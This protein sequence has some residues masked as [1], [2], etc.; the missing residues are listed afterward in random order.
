MVLEKNDFISSYMLLIKPNCVVDKLTEAERAGK[1]SDNS[2]S[3]FWVSAKLEENRRESI[4]FA[5]QL[6]QIKI[7]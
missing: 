6:H 3:I 2:N 1:A 5:L 4:P 7:K